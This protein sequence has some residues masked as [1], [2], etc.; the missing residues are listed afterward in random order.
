MNGKSL[1]CRNNESSYYISIDHR[2]SFFVLCL[3]FLIW[4]LLITSISSIRFSCLHNTRPSIPC[5]NCIWK[6]I[7]E[8][9]RLFFF[10]LIIRWLGIV[11][12]ATEESEQSDYSQFNWGLG[13]FFS[14]WIDSFM[15]IGGICFPTYNFPITTSILI[16]LIKREKKPKRILIKFIR[17]ILSNWIWNFHS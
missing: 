15:Q 11:K 5:V 3:V 10:D 1:S 4:H 13:R 14:R 2:P 12:T 8:N 16:R 9:H 17:L 6:K 7:N